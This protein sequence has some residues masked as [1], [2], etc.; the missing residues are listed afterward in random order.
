MTHPHSV[1]LVKAG[2]HEIAVSVAG[3]GPPLLLINGFGASLSIW[4]PLR[5]A[6]N[7]TTI[8][9]DAP[10]VGRSTMPRLPLTVPQLASSAVRLLDALGHDQV[11][12]L[13]VSLGGVVAEQLAVQAR[14][15]VRRLVLASTTWGVGMVPGKIRA[16]T[17]LLSPR[18][19]FVPG[20]YER[21]A[22]NFVGGRTGRE[23]E[24]AHAYGESR[25]A[26]PP[27]L[28][29]HLW[30]MTT[31]A[32]WSTLPFLHRINAPTLVLTG[33]EDP[34]LRP[35]NSRILH[36]LISGAELQI[37]PG[38]GHLLIFDSVDEVAPIINNFLHGPVT[39]T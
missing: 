5:P 14:D 38:G 27:A 8:A 6:L 3:E 26:E 20:Y 32:T 24:I 19:Y 9:F 21:T 16:W 34:L 35:L 4:D 11:D 10:G 23:P 30:Q 36:R 2:G 39:A 18:R 17:T 15:R 37:I 31:G 13:G 12:V 28:K 1:E 33:S 7:A 25:R 22:K 29:A